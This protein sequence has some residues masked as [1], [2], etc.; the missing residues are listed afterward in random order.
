MLL[1][2]LTPTDFV[3]GDRAAPVVLVHYGDFECPYSGELYPVLRELEGRF[4][5]K[6]TVAFRQ[7]PLADVH[8][9][10]LQAS[11]AAQAAGEKFWAMHDALYENQNALSERDLLS[12][13]QE[14]GLDGAT[15]SAAISAP[16]TRQAVEKS[17]ADAKHIGIHGTPSLFIN[18]Q[19]HDN[20]QGLWEMA[21][22][23]PLV[24]AALQAAK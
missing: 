18:G 14:I 6:L 20:N 2:P 8:P 11:L 10:A 3:R 19:F 22:L 9:H 1:P 21:R 4:G 15:F 24:E 13:A 7:F 17:V 5:E 23:L 12:Y 16:A